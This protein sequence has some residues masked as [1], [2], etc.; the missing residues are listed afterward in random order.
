MQPALPSV[1]QD[2]N[3]VYYVENPNRIMNP[4]AIRPH[5]RPDSAWWEDTSSHGTSV[6]VAKIDLEVK[7]PSKPPAKITIDTKDNQHITLT[8]LT[9]DIFNT[10][11][12]DNVA[13]RPSFESDEKLIDYYMRTNFEVY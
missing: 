11:V 13:G 2:I 1:N 4:I 12:R 8:A 5:I 10:K 7:E 3:Y 9:L 6:K